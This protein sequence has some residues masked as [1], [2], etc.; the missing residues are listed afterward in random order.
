MLSQCPGMPL[1]EELLE[2]EP[3]CENAEGDANSEL[4]DMEERE[5]EEDD[6]TL[7]VQQSR[8][9]HP[10]GRNFYKVCKRATSKLGTMAGGGQEEKETCSHQPIH[11]Q[12][13]FCH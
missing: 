11:H 10:V 12:S 7:P 8:T 13:N 9:V 2:V 3:G 1:F 6:S 5:D 4:L